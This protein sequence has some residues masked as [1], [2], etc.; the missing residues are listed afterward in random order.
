MAKII[1]IANQKGGV[2]KTTTAVNLSASLAHYGK[3]ILLIDS[4]PQANATTGVGILANDD[5]KTIY[6]I[7]VTN[8][9]ISQSIKKTS[10]ENLD[11]ISSNVNTSGAE[12]QLVEIISRERVLKN[13]LINFLND[14]AS[15]EKYDFIIIDCPPSLGLIT[16]N[17]LTAANSVLI[18]VQCEYYA[19]EG[20]SQLLNTVKNV[21]SYF[22]PELMIE[23]YLLTMFDARL[24]L[25][26]Q[27]ETELRKFFENKVYTTK[28]FRNVKIGEAPSFGKPLIKYDHESVGAKNYLELA[29]EFLEKNNMTFS[30]PAEIKEDNQ[31]NNNNNIEKTIT[32]FPIEG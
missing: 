15:D 31:Q 14:A 22:N 5:G 20:L 13:K 30:D 23:G 29:R 26:N 6:E 4:D 21:K 11:L 28:I 8:Q 12:I 19:L 3:K 24:K 32:D 27:V 7:L 17:A 25:A 2:G 1:S 10:I 18:P 9:P 16:V